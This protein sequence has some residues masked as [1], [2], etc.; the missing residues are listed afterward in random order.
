VAVG[1]FADPA[2]ADRAALRLRNAGLPVTV[3]PIES[4]RGPLTR[5]RVGPFATRE[6][7]LAASETVRNLGLEAR[8]Y[9]PR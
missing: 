5:V 4:A 7:A 6:E 9:G 2:N 3:D 1:L 8:V